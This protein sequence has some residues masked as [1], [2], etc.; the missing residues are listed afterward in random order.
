MN[1]IDLENAYFFDDIIEVDVKEL[2]YENGDLIPKDD[3]KHPKNGAFRAYTERGCLY[4][5]INYKD[6]MK[7]GETKCYFE[8]SEIVHWSNSY[9]DDELDGVCKKYYKNGDIDETTTF[10]KGKKEGI[11]KSYFKSGK[12]YSEETYANNMQNGKAATYYPSGQ[13]E[14]S[15]FFVDD[16][17]TGEYFKYF[18]NGE[19][20]TKSIWKNDLKIS[21]ISYYK[22]GEVESIREKDAEFEYWYYESGKLECKIAIKDYKRDGEI[23]NY[24]ENGKIESEGNYRNGNLEGKYTTYFKN[25]KIKRVSYYKKGELDGERIVYWSNGKI[26][27]ATEFK[28]GK[29]HGKF[30][31]YYKSGNIEYQSNYVEDIREGIAIQFSESGKILSRVLF[32]NGA[33]ID[34]M[35]PKG[36][37]KNEVKKQEK[38]KKTPKKAKKIIKKSNFNLDFVNCSRDIKDLTEKIVKSGRLDFSICIYGEPGVGKSAYAEYLAERLGLC[39]IKKTAGDILD[40]YIGNSEQKIKEAFEEAEK[41]KCV[42]IIDEVDSFLRSRGMST[43]SWE[44][45]MVNQMLTSM[46][47]FSYPFFCTTNFI[48]I[49][50][51]ASLRRF[52]FKLGFGFLKPEQIKNAF[53]FVFGFAPNSKILAMKGLTVSDFVNVKKECDILLIDDVEEIAKMLAEI[54]ALKKSE[55]LKHSVGF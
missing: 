20:K 17:Q 3:F 54:I 53:E 50:D 35:T 31:C 52:T 37:S 14:Q 42:L 5:E 47:D 36:G 44:I 9:T 15:A 49:L 40:Q 22:N 16:M 30:T 13:I 46:Q 4:L 27:R 39:V 23:T 51:D 33:I 28:N 38:T 12:L 45:T 2:F 1:E 32:K 26:K 29:L 19:I 6:G 25:G 24:Y 43:K 10:V 41:K 8:N 55:E 34:D 48:D 11:S 18:D 7:N 21:S